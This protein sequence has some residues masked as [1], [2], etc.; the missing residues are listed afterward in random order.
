VS[1]IVSARRCQILIGSETAVRFPWRAGLGSECVQSSSKEQQ[2]ELGSEVSYPHWPSPNCTLPCLI[3]TVCG[4][5]VIGLGC[6]LLCTARSLRRV[7]PGV[8]AHCSGW[9]G[10]VAA[11]PEVPSKHRRHLSRSRPESYPFSFFIRRHPF[12]YVGH[13]QD[14]M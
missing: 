1:S 7:K 6:S 12:K 4:W 10:R 2:L 11:K 14:I 5:P 9:L 13:F 8:G 3:D